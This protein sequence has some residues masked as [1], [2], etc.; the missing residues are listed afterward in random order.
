MATKPSESSYFRIRM[1]ARTGAFGAVDWYLNGFVRPIAKRTEDGRGWMIEADFI[2]NPHSTSVFPS[3]ERLFH[4]LAEESK[5][6]QDEK[7]TDEI[8][9]FKAYYMGKITYTEFM[10][11][12]AGMPVERIVE[13]FKGVLEDYRAEETEQKDA[14]EKTLDK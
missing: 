5:K 10:T 9:L 1:N 3:L 7:R 13:N 12:I 8:T 4:D 14:P 2:E 6:S 11:K